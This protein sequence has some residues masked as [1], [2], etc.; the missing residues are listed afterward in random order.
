MKILHCVVPYDIQSGYSERDKAP[1]RRL[2]F[3]APRFTQTVC[4]IFIF[5]II[6]LQARLAFL[7][8][9]IIV[10]NKTK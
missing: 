1:H 3:G 7:V 6:I 2:H 4:V 5:T 8:S 10:Y 9:E